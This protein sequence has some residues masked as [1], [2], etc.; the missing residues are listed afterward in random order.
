[1]PFAIKSLFSW[2]PS[3]NAVR[4]NSGTPRIAPDVQKTRAKSQD[5]K[6]EQEPNPA[7]KG[8]RVVLCSVSPWFRPPAPLSSGVG[9]VKSQAR[10]V[11]AKRQGQW[12]RKLIKLDVIVIF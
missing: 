7:L 2:F 8:T 5:Q 9:H 12:V 10:A 6:Q 11:F 4:H 3:S 1:M